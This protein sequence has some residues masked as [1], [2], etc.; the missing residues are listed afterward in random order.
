MPISNIIYE[1]GSIKTLFTGMD[2]K[3]QNAPTWKH[4]KGK[5]Q[6]V[7]PRVNAFPYNI[8]GGR[9]M[10]GWLRDTFLEPG[11]DSIEVEKIRYAQAYILEILR[12]YLMPDKLRSLV[13]MRWLLKLIDF[14]AG[15][16]LS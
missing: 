3:I 2:Q 6:K 11:D 9:I 4:F 8:Y 12:G 14:K 10:M 13:H 5:F 15:G 7:R 16:E 1:N